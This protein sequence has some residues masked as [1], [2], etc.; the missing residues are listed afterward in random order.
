[1]ACFVLSMAIGFSGWSLYTAFSGLPDAT[2]VR[3]AGS[4]DRATTIVD[5]KGRH[6]FTIFKEQRLEVPL[7]RVSPNL[8]RAMLAIEDQRFYDHGGVDVIR[9]A[10]AAMN[11]VIKWRAAQGG[12]TITQQVARLTFLKPEKTIH[13]KLQ[14]AIL[15]MRLETH[16]HARTR[17]S[18]CT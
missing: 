9:I 16:V 11:N 7:S 5:V 1:M 8:V 14:E 18:S 6:A 3:A 4:M 12:S 2:A 13:R 17:S 10:G 15:A